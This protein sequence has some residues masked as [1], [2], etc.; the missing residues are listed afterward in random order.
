MK[1]SRI[2]FLSIIILF[3]GCSS[4]DKN[5][6]SERINSVENLTVYAAN[7]QPPHQIKFKEEQTFGGTNEIN[8]GE[9]KSVAID[10]VGRVY[11][12]DAKQRNIK[13]YKADGDFLTLLGK[14]GQGPG[15]FN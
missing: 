13:V 6:L 5:N 8:I 14:E 4:N 9:L 7:A 1:L 10:G 15:E 2:T 12:A 3:I 11:L